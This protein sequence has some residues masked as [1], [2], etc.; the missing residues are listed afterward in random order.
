MSNIRLFQGLSIAF[1]IGTAALCIAGCRQMPMRADIDKP[2][3]TAYELAP[4]APLVPSES[5]PELIEADPIPSIVYSQAPA[6]VEPT[7]P[8]Y[9]SEELEIL[10]LIIYQ[11]AG[12]DTCL[13]S[14]R[15]MVGEVFLN[16]VANP[17][18]PDS[19]YEVA[20][21]KYQYGRLY[22]TGLVWPERASLPQERHAVERA[23]TVAKDLL[24]EKVDR[25][26]PLDAIFQ[27]EFKQGSKVLASQ[28]GFYFCK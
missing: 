27:A 8:A 21:Q 17:N 24:T 15:Q 20:V 18:Y 14:T 4:S 10:A 3:P 16:R 25:F 11:E 28:D 1:C 2:V 6:P 7:Q 5:V 26:L 12:G 13:D 19:F 22:W 23:Y 9:T